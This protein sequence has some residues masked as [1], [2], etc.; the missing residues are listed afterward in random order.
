MPHYAVADK[1]T[2]NYRKRLAEAAEEDLGDS[3]DRGPLLTIENLFEAPSS[4]SRAEVVTRLFTWKSVLKNTTTNP[5][6]CRT[7]SAD[8]REGDLV[9]MFIGAGEPYIVR[10]EDDGYVLIGSATFGPHN[11][12]VWED[13][14]RGYEGGTLLLQDFEIQ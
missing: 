4:F 12:S 13:C 8:P 11:A 6:K 3:N 14:V 5:S 7:H 9:C 2:E 1:F 10:E